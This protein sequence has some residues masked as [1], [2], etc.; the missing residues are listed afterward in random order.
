MCPYTR[1]ERRAPCLASLS[2]PLGRW[3]RSRVARTPGFGELRPQHGAL[4]VKGAHAVRSI[5][6]LGQRQKVDVRIV[7]VPAHARH[8]RASGTCGTHERLRRPAMPENRH[9]HAPARDRVLGHDDA[10][11]LPHAREELHD[12]SPVDEA[13][14]RKVADPHAVLFE[15]C[16]ALRGLVQ[17]GCTGVGRRRR[18]RDSAVHWSGLRANAGAVA[19]IAAIAAVVAV[20]KRGVGRAHSGC[21]NRRSRARWCS[22]RRR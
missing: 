5:L 2:S 10:V 22:G 11:D 12:R 7:A 15:R 14:F 9:S 1:C 20:N 21:R 19:I 6:G 13:S 16:H 18:R 8:S 3:R 4:K 17:R